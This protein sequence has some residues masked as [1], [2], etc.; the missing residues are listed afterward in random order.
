M[1]EVSIENSFYLAF[2]KIVCDAR[3][4]PLRHK[5]MDYY[6]G[7]GETTKKKVFKKHCN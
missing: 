1:E 7:E 4:P 5:W 2:R 6:G 3:L